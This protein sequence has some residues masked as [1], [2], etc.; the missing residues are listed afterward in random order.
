MDGGNERVEV[1]GGGCGAKGENFL[2][3]VV[4]NIKHV[5]CDQEDMT[6]PNTKVKSSDTEGR[7][8]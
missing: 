7:R 3:R 4:K 2:C 6:F 8:G 5:F 1:L